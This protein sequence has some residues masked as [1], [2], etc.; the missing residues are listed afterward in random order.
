MTAFVTN[1][2]VAR[3]RPAW[4]LSGISC[5]QGEAAEQMEIG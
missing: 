5:R 4:Q 3:I 2:A 1:S